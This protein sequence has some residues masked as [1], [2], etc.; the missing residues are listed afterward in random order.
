MIHFNSGIEIEGVD[1]PLD[2]TRKRDFAFVSHAHSDHCARHNKILATPETV[3]FFR[4]RFSRVKSIAVPLGQRTKVGNIDVELYSS[5]HILG[6][7]QIMI[8]QNGRKIVYTGDFKLRQSA[9]VQPIEIKKCDV[10]VMETTYGRPEYVFPDR[11]VSIDLLLKFI[12]ATRVSGYTP[13]ILGY[14]LGKAQEALK[15][16]GDEGYPASL[17][18][19]VYEMAMLYKKCGIKFGEFELFDRETYKDKILIAPPGWSRNSDMKGL[20]RVRS[21]MLTG[22]SV[23]SLPRWSGADTTVPLSDH[24]DYNE[25][26]AYVEKAQPKKILTIHGF[27]E[28]AADLCKRGYDAVHLGKGESVY[29]DERPTKYSPNKRTGNVDLFE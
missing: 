21:C 18:S 9:T 23:G 15:I 3:I 28:F 26:I 22:W 6:A 14:S 29:L 13:M 24:A 10:L 11:D 5:G 17:H 25:L 16:I 12:K 7:A 27:K 2:S 1:I 20:R 8:H 19:S 4:K